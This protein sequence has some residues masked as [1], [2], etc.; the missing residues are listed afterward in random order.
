MSEFKEGF[1]AEQGPEQVLLAL[2]NAAEKGLWVKLTVFGLGADE[3]PTTQKVM[4]WSF[5]GNLV[6]IETRNGEGM[7]V[8]VSRIKMVQL[9]EAN[10]EEN[11]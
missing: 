9:P 10:E 4:P 8:E 11:N 1:Y 7:A 5:E 3:P 6:W 2:E